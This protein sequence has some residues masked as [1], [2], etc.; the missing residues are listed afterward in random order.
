MIKVFI[1]I[2]ALVVSPVIFADH[3][4]HH[5]DSDSQTVETIS[6]KKCE[7]DKAKCKNNHSKHDEKC[8]HDETKCKNDHS[9]HDENVDTP[10]AN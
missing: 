3:G 6:E 8:K 2:L 9:K 4:S 10:T 7:H 5:N 1:S